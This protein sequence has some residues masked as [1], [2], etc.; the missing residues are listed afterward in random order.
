MP[1][2]NNIKIYKLVCKDPTITEC[3]IGSTTNLIKRFYQHKTCCNNEQLKD[4]NQK[5]YL[6][7]RA[8]GG[9]DNWNMILVEDYPCNDNLQARQRERYWQ[10]FYNAQL[11][12]KLAQCDSKEYHREYYQLNKDKIKDYYQ[13]NIP[14]LK[15]QRQENIDKYRKY[16]REYHKIYRKKNIQKIN[17]LKFVLIVLS[18][19]LN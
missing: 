10:E 9:F 11:N 1:E 4:Y 19:F 14:K 5:K 6:F 13:Q 16:Q 12:M 8:N 3:Y 17:F 15:A 18:V 2:Y 7:I